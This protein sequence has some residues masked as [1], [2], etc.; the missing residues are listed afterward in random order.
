MYQTKTLGQ[1]VREARDND[2]NGETQ[3]SKF[4]SQNMREDINRTEAYYNSQ[5]TSGNTDADGRPKPF[6]NICYPATNIWYRAT[7]IDSK[8]L[9]IRAKNE[10]QVVPAFLAS[11]LLQQWMNS[12]NFGQFLNDWGHVLAKHGSAV[13]E[14]VEKDGKL[15][16]RVLDW[17]NIIV[18]PIDFDSNIKIK[19][20]FLTPSQLK[21][22]KNYDQE[23]VQDLLDNLEARETSD[24]RKKDNKA[25]YI[26]VYEVHGELPLSYI[27][28][29]D[30]DE[31]TYVQ[32]MHVLAFNAKKDT[33]EYD[34]FC[35]YSGREKR[36]PLT[37]TQ[38][39]KIEGQT[40]VGGA[41]KNLFEAQWM[42]NDSE[43]M[44]RDQLLLG[45]KLV[46]QGSDE[47]MVGANFFSGVDNGE[48][49]LHKPGEPATRLELSP[50]IAALQSYQG[51]WKQHANTVNGIADAMVSQAKSGTAWRQ[52][53]AELQE[54]HSLFELMTET[55]GLYLKQIFND[56]VIDFFKKQLDND[57]AISKILESHEIKQID[58][59]YLPS[60]TNRR[61]NQ[62]KKDTIL[63]GELYDPA[64]EQTDMAE[65]GQQVESELTGNQRFIKPSSGSWKKE[66]EDLDWELELD[67]TGESENVQEKMAS[68][69]T[70]LTFLVGLQGRQMTPDESVVF[71]ELLMASG[72]ITPLKMSVNQTKTQQPQ[73]IQPQT[74]Q[75][76]QTTQV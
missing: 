44:M 7:D 36:D 27:T 46:L 71:Q 75:P 47:G 51:N 55:K 65:M 21:K 24:G 68:L 20:L 57:D 38:L 5:F 33:D 37:L 40:Y 73:P 23:M 8:D 28:K 30:G 25:G 26:E 45:S 66:F 41:V 74:M 19:R 60:E 56:Y 12:E 9:R 16:C 13:V 58:D 72:S 17:N 62:K 50:D 52:T 11:I 35:L 54:A 43:K 70:A 67:V 63:S 69:N 34:D 39:I 49:L 64:M 53:Q 31:D 48:Y 15:N 42:T 32:Q 18:D 76:A 22:N 1:L 3:L 10:K 59:R 2:E 29:K 61:V 4:V 6:M 14:I